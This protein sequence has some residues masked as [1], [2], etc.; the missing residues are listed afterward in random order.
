MVTILNQLNHKQMPTV[1]TA[2]YR[3]TQAEFY[4]IVR[5]L[6]KNYKANLAKFTTHKPKYTLAFGD[7]ILTALDA[8]EAM[9]SKEERDADAETFRQQMIPM[10]KK[11]TDNWNILESYIKGVWD[12]TE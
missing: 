5:L 6:I 1:I 2:D 8:A 3:C 9:K 12:K 11:C 4:A 10:N 7:A